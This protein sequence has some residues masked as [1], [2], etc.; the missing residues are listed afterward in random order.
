M[1]IPSNTSRYLKKCSLTTLEFENSLTQCQ[2][3]LESNIPKFVAE[4]LGPKYST[5]TLEECKYNLL[6]SRLQKKFEIPKE[7][8]SAERRERSIQAMLDYDSK[9]LKTF[10][11]HKDIKTSMSKWVLYRAR[12][13][14]DE[15]FHSF[16]MDYTNFAF[17]SNRVAFNL[18]DDVSLEEK[19]TNKDCWEVTFDCVDMFCRIAYANLYLKRIAKKHIGSVT[20]LERKLLYT[21]YKQFR[22]CGYRIFKALLVKYVLIITSG[23]RVSTVPKNNEVDRVIIVEPLCNMVCQR[24]IAL[25][26]IK[27]AN[28]SDHFHINLTDG[29]ELHKMMISDYQNATI[30][31][32]NASNSVY[33]SVIKWLW[34]KSVV[35]KL[36]DARSEHVVVDDDYVPLTMLSAMGNGFTFEVMTLT[37]LAIARILDSGAMVYGDDVI[38]DCD[39]ADTFIESCTQIGFNTNPTKT[40]LSGSF[41]ESCGG[42]ISHGEYLKSFDFEYPTTWFDL[43]VCINK[44]RILSFKLDDCMLKKVYKRLLSLTPVVAWSAAPYD[45]NL[46]EGSIFVDAHYLIRKRKSDKVSREAHKVRSRNV[47]VHYR[48]DLQYKNEPYPIFKI[49]RKSRASRNEYDPLI[50]LAAQLFEPGSNG[51]TSR[52]YVNL[53]WLPSGSADG[54]NTTQTIDTLQVVYDVLA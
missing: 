31:F 43:V 22:N 42:F 17:P 36:L 54:V 38:I 5:M 2:Q 25:N 33:T 7:T 48:N 39:V 16:R 10:C 14:L 32:A 24:C 21:K 52:I 34:P 40:F 35:N 41:R 29:Q 23:G 49:T 26:L 37:L 47:I 27:H 44:I 51:C 3:I 30:D 13:V 46:L 4:P 28:K 12:T 8:N 9:G 53:P 19:L 15:A 50:L 20:K 1:K 11:G 45:E 18:G 6:I